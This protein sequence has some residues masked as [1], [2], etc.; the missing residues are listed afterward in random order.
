MRTRGLIPA[1]MVLSAAFMQSCSQPDTVDRFLSRSAAGQGNVFSFKVDMSDSAATYD[2]AIY[3]RIDCSSRRFEEVE[4]A[5]GI[6]AEW[7]SPDSVSYREFFYLPKSSFSDATAFSHS[8]RKSYRSGLVPVQ[9][10]I[11]TLSF[12][13]LSDALKYMDGLGLVC[14]KNTEE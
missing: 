2:L 3:T 12:V 14:R 10:G 6:G 5:I 11:W 9:P 1:V 8:Y 4:D 7:M 13:V